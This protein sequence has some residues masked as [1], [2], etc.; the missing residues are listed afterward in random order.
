MRELFPKNAVQY[1]VSYYDYYQPE[2]YVPVERHVHRQGRDHQ[3]RTS[4]GC[5][6]R[7]RTRSCRGATSSSSRRC[8]C[9][10]GIGSAESYHGLLIELKVG[11]G[12]PARQPA[13][14]AR[15]HPVRAKRRRLPP[16][17]VPRA[18]RRR[19]GLP[20][21]RGGDRDP[22]RVLRRHDRGDQGGRPAAR[23]RCMGTL[24]RYA[25]YPG[26]HYVTPQEQMRRAIDEHPR[27]APRAARL[28]RQGGALPREAAARAADACTT[29]R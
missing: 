9:I 13:P 11:R 7:R 15:R 12:V 19:R 29:S 16:R 25:I 22:D 21:V 27:G 26:S 6:T 8:S 1:F 5:A 2:A 3:R 24:E 10:Y 28:L 20:G 4:T 18:R 14:H 17:D 23:A